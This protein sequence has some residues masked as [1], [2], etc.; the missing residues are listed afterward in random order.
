MNKGL[1]IAIFGV[2]GLAA[3]IGIF[4]AT[5][6]LKI[7]LSA[8]P[9]AQT[10]KQPVGGGNRQS[11]DWQTYKSDGYG[12]SLS[13]PQDWMAKENSA[14]ETQVNSPD[15]KAFVFVTALMDPSLGGEGALAKSIDE[16]EKS[17]K[18]KTDTKVYE[19]KGEAQDQIGGFILAGETYLNDASY[20]FEERGLLA[21]NGRVLIMRGMVLAT[22]FNTYA[23][24]LAKIMDS[25][26][27]SR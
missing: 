17:I 12:Y 27:A 26:G 19:F 20:R 24:T 8:S 16:Y 14:S 25:F 7:R 6:V 5:G 22:E 15:A 9:S 10:Q 23:S 4:M 11:E 3:L 18:A 21:T 2:V 1:K 13:Y